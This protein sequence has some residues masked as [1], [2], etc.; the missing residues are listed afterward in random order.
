MPKEKH[1]CYSAKR[2]EQQFGTL[3][4]ISAII[5]KELGGKETFERILEEINK[6]VDY[7]SA[8]LFVLNKHEERLEEVAKT[9][10]RGDL[11]SFVKFDLGKGFSSWVAKYRRPILMPNIKRYRESLDN[12][13][14][15]FISV[16]ILLED[17]LIG[18]LNV[19]NERVASYDEA[20]LKLIHIIASQIS[21][22][23]ERM[24]FRT[25]LSQLQ[26]GL[27]ARNK[28][29][30]DL[31]SMV[32]RL[33]AAKPVPVRRTS[34]AKLSEE[35]VKGISEPIASMANNTKFLRVSLK[36]KDQRLKKSL[37]EIEAGITQI[38]DFSNLLR[39]VN[40]R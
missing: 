11:I 2:V 28:K 23:M 8:C 38:S 3:H 31:E 22:L 37:D 13:I 17:E 9:G 4:Q 10:K 7:S 25:E 5:Q 12:H 30:K 35:V 18:V 26:T 21:A 1:D 39:T 16:P 19:S 24:Y 14:R 34:R 20:D 32:D 36:G 6:A 33:G 15:S 40:K 27:D 29:I